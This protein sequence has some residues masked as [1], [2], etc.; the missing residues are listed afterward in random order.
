MADTKSEPLHLNK[1]P[2]WYEYPKALSLRLKKKDSAALYFDKFI[3][4]R[5]QNCT[6]HFVSCK[7]YDFSFHAKS[8]SG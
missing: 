6:C 7:L 1:L 5:Q 2:A 3:G 4:E 8:A